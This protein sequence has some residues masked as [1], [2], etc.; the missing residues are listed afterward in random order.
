MKVVSTSQ[1]DKSISYANL[2]AELN[3]DTS[4][5]IGLGPFSQE[6]NADYLKTMEDSQ[7]SMS[8]NYY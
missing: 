4:V 5:K 2:L 7:V 6:A 3:V 1:L 8:L